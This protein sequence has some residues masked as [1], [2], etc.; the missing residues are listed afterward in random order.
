VGHYI[1]QPHEREVLGGRR[2]RKDLAPNRFLG[3][4]R[5]PW[6]QKGT[7]SSRVIWNGNVV[8]ASGIPANFWIANSR[9]DLSLMSSHPLARRPT[10]VSEASRFT[11]MP[12]RGT[13]LGRSLWPQLAFWLRTDQ[14]RHHTLIIW[15]SLAYIS[16]FVCIKLPR[17]FG[18]PESRF[19]DPIVC[20]AYVLSK[21]GQ[22]LRCKPMKSAKVAAALAPETVDF[23]DERQDTTSSLVQWRR[24]SSDFSMKM[25]P[26]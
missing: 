6:G 3:V 10:R 11:F 25:P 26:Q 9:M 23:A 22:W 16:C 19:A 12:S 21:T 15:T 8:R 17:T 13:S 20:D 2:P 14:L 24:R 4:R 18:V 1:W 7:S 5:R